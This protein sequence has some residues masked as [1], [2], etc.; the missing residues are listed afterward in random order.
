MIKTTLKVE[1]MACE[2]CESHVSDAVRGLLGPVRVVSS[3]RRAETVIWTETAP[4]AEALR[5][6]VAATGYTLSECQSEEA[7]EEGLLARLRRLFGG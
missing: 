3:H 2:M 1:G 6:A 4:D 7:R 5:A